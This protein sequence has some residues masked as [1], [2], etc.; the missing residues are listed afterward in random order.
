MKLNIQMIYGE[1]YFKDWNPIYKTDATIRNCIC[2]QIYEPSISKPVCEYLYIIL[3]DSLNQLPSFNE[4]LS[5]LCIGTPSEEILKKKKYNI[6]YKDTTTS[7]NEVLNYAL[8]T[9]AKYDKFE[10]DLQE[11]LDNRLPLRKLGEITF[12]FVRNPIFVQGPSFQRFFHI[13]GNLPR[14]NNTKYDHYIEMYYGKDM[15]YIPLDDIVQLTSDKE[16]LSSA[17]ATTPTMYSGAPFGFRSLFYN[18]SLEGVSFARITI[19]EVLNTITEKDF[20]L[21]EIFGHY[22]KKGMLMQNITNYNRPKNL[23][24]ILSNLINHH[25]I[26]EREF[27]SV[28]ENYHWNIFDTYFCMVFRSKMNTESMNEKFL[29]AL[30]LELTLHIPSECYLVQYPDIIFVFNLTTIKKTQE[31]IVNS[32]LPILRDNLF[33]AGISSNFTDFKNLYYYYQQAIHALKLGQEQNPMFWYFYFDDYYL[34]YIINKCKEKQITDALIP[35][36]LMRLINYDKKKGTDYA[37]LLE[38]YLE[39]HKNIADTT[40]QE[41]LH[42]NTFAY[43]IKRILAISKL[44]L[45]DYDTCLSLQIAFKILHE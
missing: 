23:D 25:L 38:V 37:H 21:I 6:L 4:N 5:F 33:M 28:L 18:L 39:N 42:R 8:R 29:N 9:Y 44:D 2:P 16:Y 14:K 27:L 1:T 43:R 45:Q 17:Y 35:K 10:H 22:L 26:D 41:F 12:E 32:I 20:A 7:I 40:R 15:T 11:V 3:A 13:T 31:T 34:S 30:A 24:Y 36:G 19:D